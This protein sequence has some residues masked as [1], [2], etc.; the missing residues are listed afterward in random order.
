MSCWYSRFHPSW[1]LLFV[2]WFP[3]CPRPPWRAGE[4]WRW[5]GR[6]GPP[7]GRSAAPIVIEAYRR[8]AR[9]G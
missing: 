8:W 5:D 2:I 4:R 3:A 9:G 1:N 7:E 6:E